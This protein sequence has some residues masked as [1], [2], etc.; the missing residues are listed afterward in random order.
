MSSALWEK[1]EKS[2]KTLKDSLDSQR[3]ISVDFAPSE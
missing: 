3:I 1:I 2:Q